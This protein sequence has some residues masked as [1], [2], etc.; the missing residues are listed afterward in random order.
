MTATTE[1][2]QALI[3]FVSKLVADRKISMAQIGT[4]CDSF[5]VT[6]LSLLISRVDLVPAV[7]AAIVNE[8]GGE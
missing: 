6:A 4:I 2:Y 7:F 1:G 5:G 8:T 3:K